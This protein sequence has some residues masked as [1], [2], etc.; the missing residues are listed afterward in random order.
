MKKL[1]FLLIVLLFSLSATSQKKVAIKNGNRDLVFSSSIPL[2]EAFSAA[3]PGDTIYIP[4]GIFV[5]NSPIT[6]R[7]VM[8]GVGHYAD[9]TAA[10]LVT[11]IGSE[12]TFSGE[13]DNS[14][15][16]GIEVGSINIESTADSLYFR[17]CSLGNIN[18]I[19]DNQPNTQSENN[20][21]IQN[22]IRGRIL[23]E[24][25][26]HNFFSNNFIT[27]DVQNGTYNV[28]LNNIFTSY[29]IIRD[30]D[31]STFANNIFA[32]PV[33]IVEFIVLN[34]ENTT[35]T[36]NLIDRYFTN[37]VNFFD[38][39]YFE[40]DP[41]SIFTNAPNWSFS[42]SYNYH[43]PNRPSYLG[44][45]GTQ[46]GIYG[47]LFSFKEGAVPQIPHFQSINIAPATN[48]NGLLNLK[49]KVNAQSN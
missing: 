4:G 48:Q 44:T 31:N 39:N 14:Y 49:I 32:Y 34:S 13:S 19:N 30:A 47:G 27:Q 21:F 26:Y 40:H 43:I 36:K 1:A 35:F 28:F 11:S 16:E 8:F 9:S 3:I 25:S 24:D 41:Y 2:E 42:Y 29:N 38:N 15:I 45:D 17:K 7:I 33:P 46:I 22:L 6:K 12:L 37:G 20:K 10:T 5:L 18:F 23:Q